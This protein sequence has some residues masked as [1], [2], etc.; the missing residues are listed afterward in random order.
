[1]VLLLQGLG[2]YLL[3]LAA[4]LA[5]FA[6][7]SRLFPHP[8]VAW[9]LARPLGMALPAFFSWYVGQVGFAH[10]VWVGL[11]LLGVGIFLAGPG[12][13]KRRKDVYKLEL[14]GLTSFWALALLRAPNFPVTGT[15]KPMDLAIL[16]TLLR[17]QPL[18]PEDPWLA[19][20]PLAYYHWGFLPWLL[21]GKLSGFFPDQLYN[22]LVP[23]LAGVV[24]QLAF[25]W[26]RASGLAF[27]PSLGAAGSCVFL[28]TAQ[29]WAELGSSRLAS[30]DLWQ[31]SR[32]IAH[33]ITEFPLFTFHLGDLH[34]HLLCQPW[35]LA[36]LLVL[37]LGRGW[38]RW[39][40]GA[41]FY[42]LTAAANPWAAPLLAFLMAALLWP[43]H[44]HLGRA[45]LQVFG[46]CLGGLLLFSPAWGS[47]PATSLG[48]GWVATPTTFRELLQVL[49]PVLLLPL[50][51]AFVHT[52]PRVF[53]FYTLATVT[54]A[55]LSSRPLLALA[56]VLAAR[57]ILLARAKASLRVS[58]T[59]VAANLLLLAGMELFY[60]RDPY[61]PDWYRMNTVF[62]IL[63]F[64]FLALPVPVWRLFS[65]QYWG[66]PRKLAAFAI[67]P[68]LLSAPQLVAVVKNAWPLPTDF[69]GLAWMAPGEAQAARYL[70]GQ[71]RREVLV[72]AV[73]QAYTSAAR[74]SAASGQPAVLGWENHELLWRSTSIQKELARRRSLVEALYHC[75]HPDCVR[76]IGRELGATMLILGSEERR[77]YPQMQEAV[78]SQAGEVIFRQGQVVLVRLFPSE[79]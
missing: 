51:G 48:L 68:W 19:G 7:T 54:A 70:H 21:L 13:W 44:G 1:M 9:A 60:V 72:E 57:L 32:G 56:G 29:G 61:G 3:G 37:E 33:A 78:L 65:D 26:S 18:P 31:A 15:E 58:A 14:L 75:S 5:G 20:Y 4:A 50:V 38:A 11:P 28:G 49:S 73:G 76:G 74:I 62:K 69:S 39:A 24:V 23:S 64:C 79:P 71:R 34:P 27:W 42:G 8:L 45:L 30:A 46:C 16:A 12:A 10:W 43:F 22:L 25:A 52:K 77:L 55:L 63:S 2:W 66:R 36:T 47:L 35:V 17:A 6:L 67:A 41:F 40:L 59:L 53:A